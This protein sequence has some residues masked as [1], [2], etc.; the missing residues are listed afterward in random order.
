MTIEFSTYRSVSDTKPTGALSLGDLITSIKGESNRTQVERIRRLVSEKEIEKAKEVKKGLPAVTPSGIFK[1]RCIAGLQSHS[2]ILCIDFDHCGRGAKIGLSSDKHTLLVFTS[3]GGEG[4]KLFVRIDPARHE[5][6]FTYAERYYREQYDLTVDP[7]CSDVSRLC[8]LSYDPEIVFRPNADLLP[9]DDK[10]QEST[11]PSNNPVITQC[12]SSDNPVRIQC[13]SNDNTVQVVTSPVGDGDVSLF[14]IE[15]LIQRTIPQQAGKRNYQAMW[16]ARG[17]RF[18]CGLPPL[19]LGKLK[20]YARQWYTAAEPYIG[21]KNF[22]ETFGDIVQGY[23]NATKPLEAPSTK[24]SK[25]WEMV[26]TGSI[27]AAES[28]E[29]EDERIKKLVNL[30]YA[31][32]D[33]KGEFFLSG[34]S[35]GPLIGVSHTQ[36]HSWLVKLLNT[37]LGIIELVKAGNSHA[38]N[39]Y[40]WKGIQ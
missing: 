13:K 29:F 30:C 5:E 9:F 20:D 28:D 19:T 35:S 37:Q 8:F 7:Q 11:L 24:L 6:S 25:A 12:E 34:K 27:H 31:L 38:A 15:E 17:L 2:G 14:S 23:K 18:N 1:K 40:R 36:A 16:F 22:D 10:P 32:R 21:T 39:A 4:V 33:K 3:P 26:C